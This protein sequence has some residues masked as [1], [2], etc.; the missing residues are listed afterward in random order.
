MTLATATPATQFDVAQ[1]DSLRALRDGK[2]LPRLLLIYRD[3]TSAQLDALRLA[4]VGGDRTT[5]G[6]VAHALKSASYS[7]GAAQ[8]G[9]L[10]A[11]LEQAT[12]SGAPQDTDA[13]L[14]ARIAA[15]YERL[16]PELE[17]L[18]T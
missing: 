3:Q 17:Q 12:R 13:D 4:A 15:A 16:L 8:L 2:L 1:I 7:V 10:C 9:D 18:L 14:V 5:L 6:S 11:A